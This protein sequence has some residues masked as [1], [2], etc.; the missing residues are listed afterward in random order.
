MRCERSTLCSRLGP[1]AILLAFLALAHSAP[2]AWG[3]EPART[4][5]THPTGEFSIS[6]PIEWKR[7]LF[8]AAQGG[9]GVVLGPEAGRDYKAVSRGVWIHLVPVSTDEYVV[10]E[11]L[12]ELAERL[13]KNVHPGDKLD[14]DHP[15][16]ITWCGARGTAWAIQAAAGGAA[17]R[18]GDF[19]LLV[20]RDSILAAELSSP[21]ANW[22]ADSTSFNEALDGL[23]LTPRR[24]IV[25]TP[26]QSPELPSRVAGR[27]KGSVP[28]IFAHARLDSAPATSDPAAVESLKPNMMGTGFIVSEDGYVITNRHVVARISKNGR[29]R[30]TYDPVVLNWDPIARRESD[31]AD[32]IAIG[33]QW[34]LALLKIRGNQRWTPIPMA[35][36]E[37]VHEAQ[38]VLVMGWPSVSSDAP[39]LLHHNWNVIAGLE[40]DTKLRTRVVR[41]GA[42]TT[43]GNSGG[44]LIGLEVGGLVGVHAMG[45]TS[46]AHDFMDM[47]Q[48]GAVP[49]DRLM[50]EFPQVFSGPEGELTLDE[51]VARATHFFQQERFGGAMIECRKILAVAPNH[52]LAHAYL[53][54]MLHLQNEA[55]FG[56]KHFAPAIADAK[57]R[58]LAQVFAARTALEEGDVTALGKH[59]AQAAST[60]NQLHLED[61][62]ASL[63]LAYSLSSESLF[64]IAFKESDQKDYEARTMQAAAKLRDYLI[65]NPLTK[66]SEGKRLS[67]AEGQAIDEIFLSSQQLWPAHA[68]T[69]A[70]RALLFGLHGDSESARAMANNA[71]IV[72]GHDPEVLIALAYYNLL[73]GN[74]SQA[75][76]D[77]GSAVSIRPTPGSG[78]M[79]GVACVRMANFLD[80]HA[81]DSPERKAA[82][83]V[84]A[85]IGLNASPAAMR[86]LGT[87][88]IA[89][90]RRDVR[91][92]MASQLI[93][94][95]MYGWWDFAIFTE[96]E[97]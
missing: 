56:E 83:D 15:R 10:S 28:Q 5:L 80:K 36:M 55:A 52:G 39:P 93:K 90:Q 25:A 43:G 38:Q 71:R 76:L 87:K 70:Y 81:T 63:M 31:V 26:P 45:Y 12:G 59:A 97:K 89:E 13:L 58:M 54:R 46:T 23:R 29:T 95:G 75:M 53:Y 49:A 3:Q 85:Q 88:L 18:R 21:D 79:F 14:K 35:N 94:T 42:R 61:S 33:R 8:D 16:E 51:R 37:A 65:K 17:A 74:L 1:P 62:Q 20:L 57:S 77:S 82:L 73:A 91:A 96:L 4:T 34:D 11:N 40:R 69:F 47:F 2:M 64:E 27:L 7:F 6:L 78:Y 86:D 67:D 9:V 72:G 19:R 68:P 41:H 24:P 22:T 50:W 32:V 66:F 60:A 92:R 84:L 44:P 48:H 30:Y